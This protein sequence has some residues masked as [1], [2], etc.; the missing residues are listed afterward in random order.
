M[1]KINSASPF[2]A[3]SVFLVAM[4]ISIAGG[5]LIGAIVSFVGSLFYIAF[6]FPLGM[7]FAGGDTIAV[8]IKLANIRKSTR[9]ILLSLLATISIYGTYHYGRYV[10]LQAQTFL[11]LSSR[12]DTHDVSLDG[13]KLVLDYALIKET[14]HSGFAGY[15]MYKAQQGVSLGRL[16]SSSSTNLGLV[17]SWVYWLLE[18]GIILSVTIIIGRKEILVPVCEACGSRYGREKHLGGTSVKNKSM[19]LES[20]ERRDFVEIGKLL[21]ENADLPSIEL[22]MKS[23]ESCEKGISHLTIQQA[24]KGPKGTVQFSDI[25]KVTVQPRDRLAFSR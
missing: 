8:A 24:A 9:L 12:Q 10:A 19:L 22:Y 17:L 1:E 13:A 11:E 18:I 2:K 5:A 20:I 7:G 6:L 25:S 4:V 14:G 16:V 15:M 23:C 3:I 21:E